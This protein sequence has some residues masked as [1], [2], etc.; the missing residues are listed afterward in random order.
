MQNRHYGARS[1]TFHFFMT[2]YRLSTALLDV[3]ITLV[4]ALLGLRLLMM[5]FGGNAENLFVRG[6]YVL[7][8]PLVAPFTDMFPSLTLEHDYVLEFAALFALI[9]YA[10]LAHLLLTIIRAVAY[11]AFRRRHVR[12][13]LANTA[14]RA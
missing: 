3:G 12:G 5:L 6:V 8:A 11:A 9:V 1:F 10:V 13:L 4:T 14:Q 7:S 2:L